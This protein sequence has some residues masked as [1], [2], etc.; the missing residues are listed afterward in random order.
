MTPFQ[1]DPER[2]ELE[3]VKIKVYN[4]RQSFGKALKK[5]LSALPKS[6]RKKTE[7]VKGLAKSVGLELNQS[8]KRDLS[9]EVKSKHNLVRTFF[10]EKDIVYIAPGMRDYIT[11]YKDGRKV[12]L[13][14]LYL[15]MFL[16]EA[17]SIFNARFPDTTVSFPAFCKLKPKNVL[18]LKNTPLDQCRC[19]THENFIFLLSALKIDYSDNFWQKCLCD[20]DNIDSDCWTGSCTDCSKGSKIVF[21]ENSFPSIIKYHKW[22]VDEENNQTGFRQ[23]A[24]ID[25]PCFCFKHIVF[26]LILMLKNI[27]FSLSQ[28]EKKHMFSRK[29]F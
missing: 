10:C 18:S 2:E 24:V 20:S 6:P 9:E 11:V 12:R 14:K 25:F 17:H 1:F 26:S 4:C 3:P 7:V 29:R 15:T 21:E 27:L 19:Q 5:S 16:R 8:F 23:N 13:R 22:I 28:C